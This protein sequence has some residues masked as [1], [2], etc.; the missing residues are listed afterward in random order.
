V[1][2]LDWSQDQL[3]LFTL[4]FLRLLAFFMSCAIFGAP[5][6]M[7]QIKV[8]L[9]LVLAFVFFPLI[10]PQYP[11][12]HFL[13]VEFI[14]SSAREILV[15]LC[16]GFLTRAFFF[17]VSSAGEVIS[18]SLG[19]SSAA[20][21]NPMLGSAGTVIEQFHSTMAVLLFLSING[22]HEFISVVLRSFELF[23]M[24][25][26]FLNIE[27]FFELALMG[28]QVLILA[29]KMSA[30][31]LVAMLVSNV[32]MGILGRAVPQINVLVTSFSVAI[33]L[34]VILMIV[35]LPISFGQM[36]SMI[37]WNISLLKE[38]LKVI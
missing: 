9:S 20:L 33:I 36:I 25:R 38:F 23:S 24:E 14:S 26:G 28:Q 21:F 30:P 29:I 10:S 11:P 22:H 34:G 7:V 31:M 16:L 19:L 27:N 32:G 17:G 5:N 2:L 8:L 1:N 4:I 15:G 13:E 6:V 12:S 37:G 35:S 18:T 3:I